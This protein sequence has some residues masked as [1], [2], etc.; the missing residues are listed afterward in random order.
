[1]TD[2]RKSCPSL[3]GIKG[4]DLSRIYYS[5]PSTQNIREITFTLY[6]CKGAVMWSSQLDRSR[7]KPG[8]QS[9]TIDRNNRLGVG[10][11]FLEMKSYGFG[12]E[13]FRAQNIKTIVVK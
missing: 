1:M 6:D 9:V 13:V 10:I 8:I 3:I 11:Y 7:L 4:G 12:S 5:V 2:S